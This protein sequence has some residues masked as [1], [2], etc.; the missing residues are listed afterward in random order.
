MGKT[1]KKR[2][3]FFKTMTH[4]C[5]GMFEYIGIPIFIAYMTTFISPI[6]IDNYLWNWIERVAFCF[7]VYEV[8]IVGVRKMQIDV[9]K[10]ALTALKT[11]YEKGELYCETQNQSI[12]KDLILKIDKLL[13]VKNLNQLDVINSYHNLKVH[14]ENKNIVAI[15]YEIITIQHIIETDNLLWNYTLFLRLFKG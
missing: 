14:L 12:Y 10:D 4:C 1:L 15:K 5:I 6:C 11:A 3:V 9:R 8:V 7:T 13:D 2:H